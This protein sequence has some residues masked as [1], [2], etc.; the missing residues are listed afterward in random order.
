M[1]L[2]RFWKQLSKILK[3]V[4][5]LINMETYVQ[6]TKEIVFICFNLFVKYKNS[7]TLKSLKV[8]FLVLCTPIFQNRSVE[9]D[10]GVC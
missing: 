2:N 6:E 10:L 5:I 4:Q 9:I 3:H 7:K 1:R 8:T